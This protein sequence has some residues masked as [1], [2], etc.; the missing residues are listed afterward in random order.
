M[1][2]IRSLRFEKGS[3]ERT[4]ALMSLGAATVT[5]SNHASVPCDEAQ[6]LPDAVLKVT[7][8]KG[9]SAK[10]KVVTYY[11]PHAWIAVET[12]VAAGPS[13]PIT[14]VFQ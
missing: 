14:P 7:K 6:L 13:S 10:K 8:A 12:E 1:K 5:L 4:G 3:D 11:A 9:V 2:R